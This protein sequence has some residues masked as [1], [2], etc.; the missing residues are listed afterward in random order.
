MPGTCQIS[1]STNVMRDIQIYIETSVDDKA[2]CR[3]LTDD[4]SL[5]DDIKR[6]LLTESSGMYDK[7]VSYSIIIVFCL[8]TD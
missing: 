7:Q 5:L 1:T 3:K 4:R 6:V 8:Y 2:M